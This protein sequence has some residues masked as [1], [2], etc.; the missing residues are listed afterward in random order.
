MAEK[1]REELG[2]AESRPKLVNRLH[3]SR[4]PYVRRPPI[5]LSEEHL[6]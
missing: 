1:S 6:H 2:A 5:I 3:E 4:S